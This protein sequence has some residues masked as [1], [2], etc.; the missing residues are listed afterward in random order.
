MQNELTP[1]ATMPEKIK[2][3][4]FCGE[5]PTLKHDWRYPRGIDDSIYAS[6]VICENWECPIYHADNTYYQ[7]DEEAIE[8]W[9]RR[10]ESDL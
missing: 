9:N 2:P 4:P 3:C 6:E 8:A 5:S 7:T 1:E 10:A